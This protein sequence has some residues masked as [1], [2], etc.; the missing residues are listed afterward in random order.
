MVFLLGVQKLIELGMC[1]L[2]LIK[3][4]VD[5]N[6]NPGMACT[7]HHPYLKLREEMPLILAV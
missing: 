5:N 1:M 7:Y 6:V 4:D 2:Y 3:T